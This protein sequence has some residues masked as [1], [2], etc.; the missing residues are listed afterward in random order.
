MDHCLRNNYDEYFE[1]EK[2]FD[3]CQLLLST[4]AFGLLQVV[5]R[6]AGKLLFNV[7]FGIFFVDLEYSYI[8]IF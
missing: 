8:Y 1:L 7:V 6:D 4:L 5:R 2:D 3:F